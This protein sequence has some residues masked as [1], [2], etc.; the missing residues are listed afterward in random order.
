MG[1][2]INISPN[3]IVNGMQ[4]HTACNDLFSRFEQQMLFLENW[5]RRRIPRRTFEGVSFKN[6]YKFLKIGSEIDS[7][8]F[9]TEW[10]DGPS[11]A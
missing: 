4:L 10:Q 11:Q 6:T 2:K 7:L 8:N 9:V 3:Y 1:K 5:L